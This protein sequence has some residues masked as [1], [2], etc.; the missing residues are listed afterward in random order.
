MLSRRSLLFSASA[1]ALGQ[2]LTGCSG[3]SE[4]AVK[5]RLLENSVPPPLLKVFQRQIKGTAIDL[6][7]GRQLADLFE[8]LKTWKQQNGKPANGIEIPFVSAKPTPQMDLISLGD[9]WLTPAIQQGLIQPLPLAEIAEWQQL[10]QQWQLF[11]RR[12]RQGMLSES[13][14][15]WAAPYRWGTLMLV[16]RVEAFQNRGWTPTD[17]KD[18]WRSELKGQISLPD[19]ARAVI[20]LTLKKMGQSVNLPDLPTNLESELRSL[21]QQAKFYSSDAYLQPLILEDTQVAVGWSTDILP[22]LERDRRLAAVVP[23]SGTL[24]TADL[25]VRPAQ[26]PVLTGDRLALLKK[27]I[28]FYWKPQTAAQLTL[29]SLAASPLFNSASPASTSPAIP[30][31]D[32][33][34]SKSLLLPSAEIQQ[35]SE[36]LLPI[37]APMLEQYRRLWTTVRQSKST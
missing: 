2:L 29:L 5:I 3:G 10:P 18:L 33:L 25:W 35:R 28:G 8:L 14:D 27:W 7:Q 17:W 36:L 21:H 22:L 13:G 11:V 19:S 1:F 4:A 37:A 34:K 16:Y 26:A 32:L 23:Q 20:G 24:L 6:S 15:L 31:P 12:D 30:V 9:A